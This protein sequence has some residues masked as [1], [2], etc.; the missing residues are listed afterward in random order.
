MRLHIVMVL[1]D[2]TV[3]SSHGVTVV[4]S[5]AEAERFLTL[6]AGSWSL[7]AGLP[8]DSLRRLEDLE[9]GIVRVTRV[10]CTRITSHP[11][12][13]PGLTPAV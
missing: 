9:G 2:H 10:R 6:E 12:C 3:S 7:E 5:G 8:S 4:V 1:T 13:W 11:S